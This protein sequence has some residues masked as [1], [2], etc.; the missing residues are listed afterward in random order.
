MFSFPLREDLLTHVVHMLHPSKSCFPKAFLIGYSASLRF[1]Q[2]RNVN[3]ETIE[4]ASY[5]PN[6]SQFL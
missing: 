5:A 1:E 4:N 3:R 6:R 2:G